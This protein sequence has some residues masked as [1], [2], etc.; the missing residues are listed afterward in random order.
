MPVYLFCKISEPVCNSSDLISDLDPAHFFRDS[1]AVL[2]LHISLYSDLDLRKR[3]YR[4]QIDEQH[5]QDI[6]CQKHDHSNYDL[7]S[8]ITQQFRAEGTPIVL[9]GKIR[10]C[11]AV[12]NH[13]NIAYIVII[14]VIIIKD[15][16]NSFRIFKGFSRKYLLNGTVL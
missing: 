11:F 15:L 5:K 4:F 3:S 10:Y 9:Y 12:N 7:I 13:R 8:R 14:P 16:I 2:V 1:V 6:E